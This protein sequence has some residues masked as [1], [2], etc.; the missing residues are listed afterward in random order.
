[1]NAILA[2]RTAVTTRNFSGR[3]GN[4]ASSPKNPKGSQ[5]QVAI[6]ILPQNHTNHLGTAATTKDYGEDED[7]HDIV[8]DCLPPR[9]SS[10]ATM[11]RSDRHFLLTAT[12]PASQHRGALP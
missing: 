10:L 12:T 3:R 9:Q 7:S 6:F 1:M 5:R 8:V 2:I 11:S 4:S